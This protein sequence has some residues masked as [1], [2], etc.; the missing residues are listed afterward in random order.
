MRTHEQ[1]LL[2]AGDA[3]LTGLPGIKPHQPR[4]WKIRKRIP[5]DQWVA[6]E[7]AGLATLKELAEAAAQRTAA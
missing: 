4:D 2:D 1:I 6:F 3:A 7:S 5:A